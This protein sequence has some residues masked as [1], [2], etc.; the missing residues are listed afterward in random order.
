MAAKLTTVVKPSPLNAKAGEPRS[1]QPLNMGLASNTAT[2]KR[3][4]SRR[5]LTKTTPQRTTISPPALTPMTTD[6]NAKWTPL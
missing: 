4:Q 6:W 1:R 5:P 2:S 3:S